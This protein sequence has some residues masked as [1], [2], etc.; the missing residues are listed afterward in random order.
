MA[1]YKLTQAYPKY[2]RDIFAGRDIKDFDVYSSTNDNKIGSVHD[3]L[4]DENGYFRYF[5]IDTGFWI[6]GKKVLLPIGR[7]RLDYTNERLYALGLTQEQAEALP[8]YKDDMTVDYEYEEKVRS[9]YRTED[10]QSTQYNRD[11]Y[12]YDHD[13]DLYETREADHGSL[14]LYEERLVTDKNRRKTGDVVVGKTIETETERATVPVE[15]ERV[16]VERTSPE[17]ANQPVSSGD[18]NFKDEEVA[19]I[20]V[21]EENADI[22]KETFVTEEVD[23]R[24]EVDRDTVSAEQKVRREELDVTTDGEPV[25]QHNR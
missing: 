1:L 18:S 23:V 10:A 15:R 16:V 21:Y 4:V 5:V 8:E 11:N 13:A 17:N 3:A 20:E 22:H 12:R 2:Q 25:V 19:R 9:G 24:K 7:S 14:K 6:F